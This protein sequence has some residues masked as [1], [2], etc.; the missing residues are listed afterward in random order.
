MNTQ[1]DHSN[2]T[3]P[4]IKDQH[5]LEPNFFLR[6]QEDVKL[7]ILRAVFCNAFYLADAVKQSSELI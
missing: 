2:S 5:V 4:N 7:K 6:G 1:Y 3:I